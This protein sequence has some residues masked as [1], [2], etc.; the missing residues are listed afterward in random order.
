MSQ[1]DHLIFG[2]PHLERG[3]SRLEKLLGVR[4]AAGGKHPAYGTHNALLALG[5]DCYLEVMAPDP[6]APRPDGPRLFGLD[7]LSEPRLVTWVAKHS[8]P[9]RAAERAR[10]AGVD[11]GGVSEGGRQKPDGS[12]VRWRITDPFAPRL[13]GV[14]PFLID[15]GSTPHPAG[16]A[17]P[18]CVLRG[19]R[20]EH[21]D[22]DRARGAL[23][24]LGLVLRVERAAR[25]SLIATI[26]GPRGAVEL[27]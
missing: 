6:G 27:R 12:W 4:A 11:L 8:E 10:R 22:P 2:T 14:V 24:A 25:A 9:E 26:E 19:L 3:V 15:W 5:P 13:D 23:E 7:D 18:G 21:P 20:A 1:V 16:G 17:A